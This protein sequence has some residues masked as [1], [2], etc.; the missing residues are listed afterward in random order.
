MRTD[1]HNNPAAFTTDLAHQAGLMLGTDYVEG[2]QFTVTMPD[3]HQV[4]YYT[5]KLIGDPVE[6]TIRVIDAVGYYTHAGTY[7]WTYIALPKF[8]WN[9]LSEP[10]RRDVIGF[11]YMHEGGTAMRG[12]FPNYGKA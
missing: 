7:R 6:L 1:E 4:F 9:S 2:A 10:Q 8:V 3:G 12:L 5:A 11:H